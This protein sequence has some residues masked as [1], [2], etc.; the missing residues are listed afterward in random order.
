MSE[1]SY[2][3]LFRL[4]CKRALLIG[5]GGI[6]RE[7]ARALTAHGARV[8]C[9]DKE[10]EAATA[11]AADA[12]GDWIQLDITDPDAV[13][14]TADWIGVIDILVITAAMNVRK[15]ILDY[16]PE[17]FDRV[18]S[19][20]L[21]ATF[22]VL[23]AFGR[24]MVERGSGS[25]IIF[26][27]IRDQVVEAGQSVYAAA[28]AGVIQ[29]VKTAA[30]FGQAGVRVNAI[31]P[32][33]VETPLTAQIKAHPDWYDAYAAKTAL[34]RWAAPSELAGAAVFL[35]SEAASYVTGTTIRVDG[36]WTAIDGRYTPPT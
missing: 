10:A 21:K 6:G 31:A 11:T 18:A 3:N 20:N 15:R 1:S 14:R 7:V 22:T 2:T 16:T 5:A 23:Q 4:D 32:G 35:A 30:E 27:S 26:S 36:G 33:V 19:L 17:D 24:A 25:I 8:V 12:D 9:A 34:G 29:L 28:K 13:D